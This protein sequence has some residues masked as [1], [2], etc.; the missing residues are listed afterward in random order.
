MAGIA[1]NVTRAQVQ[2]AWDS[3]SPSDNLFKFEPGC[4]IT[5]DNTGLLVPKRGKMKIQADE[6]VSFLPPSNAPEITLIKADGTHKGSTNLVNN[7]LLGDRFA[8]VQN[9]DLF[10]IND[11]FALQEDVTYRSFVSVVIGKSGNI[12]QINDL[13]TEDF[14]AGPVK[15]S[16]VTPMDGFEI[17]GVHLTGLGAGT[18]PIWGFQI[19]YGVNCKVDIQADSFAYRLGAQC[20][21]LYES[22]IKIISEGNGNLGYQAV[23]VSA[24]TRFNLHDSKCIAG[25]FGFNNFSSHYFE[26]NNVE[27]VGT[28]GR[29]LSFGVNAFKTTTPGPD[30]SS[31]NGILRGCRAEG[32]RGAESGFSFRGG[33][34]NFVLEDCEAWYNSGPGFWTAGQDEQFIT[35]KGGKYRYNGYYYNQDTGLDIAQYNTGPRSFRYEGVDYGT[36]YD[37]SS[38][39]VKTP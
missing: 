36:L 15:A 35:L 38:D 10:E 26:Y 28:Y 32:A 9:P 37:A 23:D 30:G 25:G 8:T 39:Y 1:G 22:D 13:V 14:L 2:Q 3:M 21:G 4:I 19:W 16:A 5:L 7:F 6:T 34:Y 17:E 24:C 31:S 18:S 12:I 33:S 29:G 11:L 27:A 20:A